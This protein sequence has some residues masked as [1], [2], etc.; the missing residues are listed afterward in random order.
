MTQTSQLYPNDVVD[1]QRVTIEMGGPNILIRSTAAIDWACTDALA[2]A[3]NTA[4]ETDSVVVID[5]E[6]IRCDDDLV[7]HAL[8]TSET[9]CPDHIGCRSSGVEVV[10]TG[11]LR[12][13]AETSVWAVDVRAGRFCQT[14]TAINV[15]FLQSDTWT[16]FVAIWIT[17]TKLSALTTNG[18]LITNARAHHISE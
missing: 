10:A 6:Q 11:I 4:T 16:P 2:H 3:V 12:I 8:P 9:T 1:D 17:P 7:A 14:D 18:A 5:P 15:R 13:A